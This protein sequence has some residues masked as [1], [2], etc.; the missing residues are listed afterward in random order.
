MLIVFFSVVCGA[1]PKLS[2]PP[3][4][5]EFGMSSNKLVRTS[6]LCMTVKQRAVMSGVEGIQGRFVMLPGDSSKSEAMD[7]ESK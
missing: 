3:K 1:C 7:Y 6:A 2:Q 5:T 4:I